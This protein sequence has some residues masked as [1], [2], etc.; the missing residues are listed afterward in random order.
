MITPS[1]PTTP[2]AF[3]HSQPIA[4]ITATNSTFPTRATSVSTCHHL[5]PVFSNSTTNAPN[6]SD[7]D[8]VLTCPRY[9]RTF[10][11][12]ICLICPLQI[13]R[14]DWRNSAWSTNTQQRPP[15][16]MPSRPPRIQS[17]QRSTRSHALPRNRNPPRYQHI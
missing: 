11:S 8:S 4:P 16:P 5:P 7:G 15:P 10:T 17:L 1:P 14:R 3:L 9:D 6:T 2:D 13:Y 12:L